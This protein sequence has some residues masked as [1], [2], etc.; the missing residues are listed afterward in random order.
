M[1]VVFPNIVYQ[2]KRNPLIVY[3][4]AIKQIYLNPQPYYVDVIH[5]VYGNYPDLENDK[6]VVKTIV[7][8]YYYKIIRKW[9]RGCCHELLGY[10]KMDGSDNVKF[11]NNMSEYKSELE[12]SEIEDKKINF[13]ENKVISKSTIKQILYDFIKKYHYKWIKIQNHEEE[14][15]EYA[16]Y[17][18]KKLFEDNVGTK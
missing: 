2:V 5:H 17:K 3:P 9:L 7:K 16:R 1:E 4:T 12:T 18:L 11:I 15:K 6:D 10:F 13:I 8:Y 14:F